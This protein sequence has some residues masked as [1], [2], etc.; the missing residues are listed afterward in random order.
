MYRSVNTFVLHPW[1]TQGGPVTFPA[2]A[3]HQLFVRSCNLAHHG[4]YCSHVYVCTHHSSLQHLPF[5][6]LSSLSSRAHMDEPQ[7]MRLPLGTTEW[8]HSYYTGI[9]PSALHFLQQL[10]DGASSSSPVQTSASTEESN[11]T[12]SSSFVSSP[13]F[14]HS[15]ISSQ[16]QVG[17]TRI[18]KSDVMSATLAEAATQLSFA[19]FLERCNLFK[20][21]PAAPAA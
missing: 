14:T 4:L 7:C 5:R 2:C 15:A 18:V 8:N 10:Q 19:E 11:G 6:C 13:Q 3:L 1:L 9:Q 12:A 21:F 17:P 20:S 16:V